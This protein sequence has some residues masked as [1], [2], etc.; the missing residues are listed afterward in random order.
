RQT[1]AYAVYEAER[2]AGRVERMLIVAPLSAFD[3]WVTE[4]QACFVPDGRPHVAIYG[5]YAPSD[6][7]VLLVN[8]HRLALNYDELAGW[9]AKVPTLVLLDEAHR[10]KAGRNGSHGSACLDLASA[11]GRRDVL[12]GTPAPQA[13]SDFVALLDFLWPGQSQKILPRAALASRPAPEVTHQVATAIRPL[14]ARTRKAELGLTPPILR[15]EQVPLEGLHRDIYMALRA[16]YAGSFSVSMNDRAVLAKMGSVVMYLL[17]AASNPHLLAAGSTDEDLPIFRH[18]PLP[19]EPGSRLWDLIQRYNQYE[20]PTKFQVLARLVSRNA[21]AGRKTLIW[22][23]FVRNLQ[24]LQ[25][26]FARYEPALI[27]GGV[28]TESSSPSAALTRESELQRFRNDRNCMILLANPAAM[29]EGVSLHQE[30]HDA[31]YVDRT[32]NAGQYL[33]SIDRIHRLGLPPGTESTLTFLVTAG[34]IDDVVDERVRVNATA[35]GYML[36]DPDLATM[37]LPQEDEEGYGFVLDD[38]E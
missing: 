10:M 3:A 33:Q 20:T 13:P 21:E 9:A 11:A 27:F 31:V 5:D 24:A 6:A 25:R 34:T 1:V 4:A 38:S 17:E 12:T 2:Q 8:Y 14:F 23:N 22:S 28:P 26:M 18:P 29:S 7:E 15:I 32:F 36:D 30:C 16:R 19:V 35:L 37:A